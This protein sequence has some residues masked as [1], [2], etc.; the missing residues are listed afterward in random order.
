MNFVNL[1]APAAT[2]ADFARAAA[3]IGCDV[4]AFRAVVA[5]ETGGRGFDD[6]GRPKALFEPHH[7]YRLLSG[8][9]RKAAI[10]A[11]LA[12]PKWGTRPYPRDSYPRIEAACR[13]DERVAL[14]STSWGLPQIMGFNFRAAGYASAREMVEAFITGEP[15]QLEAMAR[16]IV[17][18]GLAVPLRRRD[19]ARFARGYNG[20]AYAEN[21]YD[22]KLAKAYAHFRIETPM[23]AVVAPLPAPRIDPS[24]VD[25][26]RPTLRR[27]SSGA[28]VR[29][30]QAELVEEGEKIVI[31][32][33]FGP[34]TE[35]AL[36]R[37][38]VRLGLKPDGVAGQ[39]TWGALRVSAG[40]NKE[41]V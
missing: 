5:V 22:K 10:D 27:G 1:S 34:G 23:A 17:S 20:P 36:M 24:L 21:A 13:I 9:K 2:P 37:V 12:Y 35:A 31:D 38:Q 18:E 40:P 3:T 29:M 26:S 8:S 15:S 11:G 28:A 6:K 7:F 16:W 25:T 30:L 4:A 33:V 39:I 14:E 32:G 19:W 41:T